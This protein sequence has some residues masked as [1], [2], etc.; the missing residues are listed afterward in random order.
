M[1]YE[2]LFEKTRLQDDF[3][4]GY[5]S[6]SQP[7]QNVLS[8]VKAERFVWA[9]VVQLFPFVGINVVHHQKDISLCEIIKRLTFGDDSSDQLM[10]YFYGTFLV[11]AAGI[12]IE[13]MCPASCIFIRTK[14][15]CFGIREFTAVIRKD[16]RKQLLKSFPA[17]CPE[18]QI[19][20]IGN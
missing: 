9:T 5:R 18:N 20:Y 1:I 13:N 12:T 6:A 2:L 8:I 19:P 3:L 16:Y 15:Y 11:G 17:Y 4:G 14:L 7:V 10:I